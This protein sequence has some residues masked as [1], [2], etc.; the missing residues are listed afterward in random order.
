MLATRGCLPFRRVEGNTQSPAWEYVVFCFQR[1]EFCEQRME[2]HRALRRFA[3]WQ[4]YLATRPRKRCGGRANEPTGVVSASSVGQARAATFP[5]QQKGSAG[6]RL[7][8]AECADWEGRSERYTRTRY[9]AF[10]ASLTVSASAP[11]TATSSS[12]GDRLELH[13]RTDAH[14]SECAGGILCVETKGK[15]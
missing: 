4:T 1:H 11:T 7:S 5:D 15:P 8:S 13:I 12:Q 3:L 14:L 10:S 2:W 9:P 6:L